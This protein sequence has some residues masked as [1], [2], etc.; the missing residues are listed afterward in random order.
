MKRRIIFGVVSFRSADA[1]WA[2]AKLFLGTMFSKMNIPLDGPSV[3]IVRQC[4]PALSDILQSKFGCVATIEGVDFAGD[5]SI[6]RQRGQTVVPEK[7]FGAVLRSGVAVTVMKADLTSFPVDAV[8]N[9]ANQ[10]LQHYGGLA[11]AL[12][13]A[14]GPKIQQES[15]DYIRKYGTLNT[16]DAVALGAGF[17]PCKKIIHA[18]GPALP[19]HPNKSDVAQAEPLLKQAIKSILDKVKENHLQSVAIPAI[20]SGL[21]HFPLPLCADTIVLT[22]K[23]YYEKNSSYPPKEILLVNHD[24]PTVREME[25]ASRQILGS[26][27]PTTYSQAAASKTR[28]G[29]KMSPL[30]VQMG[31]VQLILRKGK[32]EE[33]QM[34]VIVNTTYDRDLSK[35]QISNAVLQKAG[36]KMQL[37][38]FSATKIGNVIITQPYKLRCKEVYHAFCTRR[39]DVGAQQVLHSSVTECLW[40][41]DKAGH[42]SIAFPAIGTGGLGFGKKEAAQIMSDAVARFAQASPAKIEVHFVI[43]HS[44]DGTFKAFEEQMRFLQQKPS[45]PSFT[46]AEFEQREEFHGSRASHPQIS[47]R[48]PSFQAA[49]EAEKW[50]FRLLRSSGTVVIRNNFIQHLGEKEHLQLSRLMEKPVTIVEDFEGVHASIIVDG[51]SSPDVVVAG[52]QVEAMLCNIQREFVREEETA[53][54]TFS[55]QRDVSFERQTVDHASTKF[56]D[57]MS[58]FKRQGLRVVKVDKV[59]NATLKMLFDLKKKQ[60]DCIS[61]QTMFQRVPAQ[62]CEMVCHIGF[63]AE[64]APPDDP[65]YGEGIYFT[66]SAKKAM[67]VWKGANEEY[68]HFVEAE[69]LI[70]NSTPG[71]RGLILPPAK[72]KDPQALYDSVDGG[73][74][75]RDVSVIFSGYQALPKYII[76]C[77][78]D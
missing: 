43:F 69:V 13:N 37:D 59:E 76:T 74:V 31:N 78:A 18:V 73:P 44:D 77:R 19:P 54:M 72:G 42:R 25:R 28:G 29:A 75:D 3:N 60:L 70:G 2:A 4:G 65:A 40:S 17:L 15:D 9:A 34:D 11:L 47:L 66:T 36:H 14:G 71:K 26:L 35:G 6:A 16:G 39:E 45:Q 10:G 61:G 58:A 30:T 49:D 24:E 48:A 51:E 27:S 68:L 55:A 1:E 63:H 57:K 23:Q 5:P 62:F 53:M 8:V 46:H 7:R 52:L 41:A 67:E 22:V 50:L 32:I 33:Q 20:S 38:V 12:S 64:Y 21:F 56:S